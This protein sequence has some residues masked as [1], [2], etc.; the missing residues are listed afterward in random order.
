MG[1]S[2]GGHLA[3]RLTSYLAESE[4][5]D[6]VMLIYPAYLARDGARHARAACQAARRARGTTFRPDCRERQ[7]RLGVELPRVCRPSGRRPAARRGWKS[8]RTAGT[9]SES[10]RDLPGDAKRWPELL[11]DFLRAPPAARP[12]ANPAEAAVSQGCGDRHRQKCAAVAKE[13]FDLI[14]I[15][16][17]ITHNFEKPEY[18]GVWNQ[19]F[20][21]RRALN[22]G[23]SGARTENILWNIAQRRARRPV[24]Q[25]HHP[26]DRHQQRRRQELPDAPQR[27]ADRRRHQGDRRGASRRNARSRKSSSCAASPAPMAAPVRPPHRAALDRA[28]ELAMKLADNKQVFFCDVNHVFLNLDGSIKQG[29][30]ARLAASESRGR[31]ALGAGHGAAAFAN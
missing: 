10:R 24:A 26:D 7:R 16:D 6:D 28:S 23:Y 27:P 13:K 19:F 30:D 2:A 17:S 15:G 3:A 20:A 14:M 9:A 1:Y 22:L 4:Q 5:P 31:Q 21:P 25:S 12:Q 18:Q 29:I 11:A 8:S